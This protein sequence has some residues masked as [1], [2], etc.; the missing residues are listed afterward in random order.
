MKERVISKQEYDDFRDYLVK[1]TGIVLGENKH[2]L[3]SSRLNR[4]M[5]EHNL[6]SYA[7]LL[8]LVSTGANKSICTQIV[9]AMIQ[10]EELCTVASPST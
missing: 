9:D 7:Q 10:P 8:K 2:Y 6:D 5:E 3:V 4:L 1:E